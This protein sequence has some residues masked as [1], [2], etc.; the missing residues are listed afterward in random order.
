M[1][2]IELEEKDEINFHG[3][4]CAMRQLHNITLTDLAEGLCSESE[5]Q[6]I[7]S[8]ERYPEKLMRDRLMAR[9]GVSG[10]SYEDYLQP[11]EHERWQLRQNILDSIMEKEYESVEQHLLEYEK[12]QKRS[13]VE[14]Q[15][16]FAMWLWLYKQTQKPQELC[17][18]IAKKA[19]ILTMPKIITGDLKAPLLSEQELN[20]LLEYIALQTE[21]ECR[22]TNTTFQIR[23]ALSGE[24]GEFL[25]QLEMKKPQ[26]YIEQYEYILTCIEKTQIETF[27]KAKIFP[28][29]VYYVCNFIL[30][31]DKS[32]KNIQKALRI[33]NQAIE[34]LRDTQKGYYLVELLE[35][36]YQLLQELILYFQSKK[37]Q[38]KIEKLQIMQQEAKE[39][40]DMFKQLYQENGLSPYMENDCH[41]YWE[42]NSVAIGDAI[43][44]RREMLGMSRKELAEGI[45]SERT[46]M[47]ME[48]KQA[49]S[50]LP[51]VREL[52]EKMGLCAEYT[53]ARVI[54]TDFETLQLSKKLT[55]A[56]NNYEAEKSKLLADELEKRLCMTLPHNKQVLMRVRT[57][58]EWDTGTLSEEAFLCKMKK[59][60]G[61]TISLD[62]IWKAEN[63]YLTDEEIVCIFNMA[64]SVS[65]KAEKKR[66]IELLLEICNGYI[67][68]YGFSA[69]ISIIGFTLTGIASWLGNIGKFDDSDE[70]SD[71]VFKECLMHHR[72]FNIQDSLYNNLWNYQQRLLHN[73]PIHTSYN[74]QQELK[75]CILLAK[76]TKRTALVRFFE[77]K[78]DEN[79][80][81]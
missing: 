11:D 48:L 6:R 66:Y 42:R 25:C 55:D 52:F 4:L 43:K 50:Q 44:A 51:I 7:E 81:D 68:K 56:M 45:C 62:K 63:R 29:V 74:E 31:N 13:K 34:L 26:W 10:E 69:H 64:S 16:I 18:E 70:L 5:M 78:L 61:Y 27:A 1:E 54:T 19:V 23:E 67:E 3:V 58:L 37:E 36:K 77:K 41:L 71:M 24:N 15:F 49:K 21:Y 8:G 9:M 33:C 60:L 65:D 17:L 40:A 39:W 53:R 35:Q 12:M 57:S 20:L 73:L 38:N 14:Q 47:R 28:K 80:K 2:Y 76:I 75:K 79:N 30:E 72:L 32:Y 46:L 22:T 59:A